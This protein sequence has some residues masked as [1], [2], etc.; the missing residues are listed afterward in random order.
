MAEAAARRRYKRKTRGQGEPIEAQAVEAPSGGA[1]GDRKA[2]E[3]AQ[4]AMPLPDAAGSQQAA[5]KAA[6]ATAPPQGGLGAPTA[7]PNEPVTA[8][9]SM[10]PGAGSIGSV[11]TSDADLVRAIYRRHPTEAMRR[12]VERMDRI[13]GL[14]TIPGKAAIPDMS[15]MMPPVTPRGA[16]AG[17]A[18][19]G[20][21]PSP[22]SARK[23]GPNAPEA[24]YGSAPGNLAQTTD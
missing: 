15:M 23:G 24:S 9:M 8:G 19:A 20:P 11:T 3:E 7:R 17:A 12:L 2:S 22:A 5:L 18:M 13:S 14:E 21:G 1:Y 6:L 16:S 4:A 10:G